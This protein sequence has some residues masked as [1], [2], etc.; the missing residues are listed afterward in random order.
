MTRWIVPPVGLIEPAPAPEFYVEGCGAL[1]LT[2]TCARL[3]LCSAQAPIEAASAAAQRIVCVRIVV[4]RDAVTVL[5]G[6]LALCLNA[7]RDEGPWP[8]LVP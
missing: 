6:Q 7:P 8:R 4:P 3:Y 5:L 2:A 1:E